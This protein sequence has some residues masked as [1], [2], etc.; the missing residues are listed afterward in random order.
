MVFY[1]RRPVHTIILLYH[2]ALPDII[3]HG[4]MVL[5]NL[6][7]RRRVYTLANESKRRRVECYAQ[8]I[9]RTL[10]AFSERNADDVVHPEFCWTITY[11][12]IYKSSHNSPQIVTSILRH[13][14]YLSTIH[15]FV[16]AT[17][18][19]RPTSGRVRK[20]K[21]THIWQRIASRFCPRDRIE[22]T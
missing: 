12:H 4:S 22:T 14:L 18:S 5:S 6:N 8:S 1:K 2:L 17:W 7:P 19:N 21:W 10:C 9:Q 20:T 3:R 11:T 13:Q 16:S 15:N